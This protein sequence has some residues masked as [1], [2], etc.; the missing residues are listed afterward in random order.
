M[1]WRKSRTRFAELDLSDCKGIP[2]NHLVRFPSGNQL[3]RTKI[4]DLI[5]TVRIGSDFQ[6]PLAPKR[7]YPK[8]RAGWIRSPS[9]IHFQG[10]CE[11]ER[12]HFM[13]YLRTVHR[14]RKGSSL[15]DEEEELIKQEFKECQDW[16]VENGFLKV[17]EI[18]KWKYWTQWRIDKGSYHCKLKLMDNT[19]SEFTSP[20]NS[21]YDQGIT[22]DYKD[23][24]RPDPEL[25]Y[26]WTSIEDD[27]KVFR[28]NYDPVYQQAEREL[29]ADLRQLFRYSSL[30]EIEIKIAKLRHIEGMTQPAIADQLGITQ[31]TVSYHEKRIL[32]KLR[33]A[34]ELDKTRKRKV[35]RFKQIGNGSL[36]QCT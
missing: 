13:S 5:H 17:S 12:R 32:P 18:G 20:G 22:Q 15:N 8:S 35:F 19:I 23:H 1:E 34:L 31:P 11:E 21:R 24:E 30:T 36:S 27:M 28:Q 9:F 29:R 2:Y 16:L 14:N 7:V 4:D 10:R 26:A 25:S 6:S 33:K 3:K